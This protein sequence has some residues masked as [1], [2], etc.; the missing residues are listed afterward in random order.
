MG[1]VLIIT[2]AVIAFAAN[3][4]LTRIALEGQF[5]DPSAFALIRAVSGAA[6]L[7]MIISVR[8]EASQIFRSAR[9]VGAFS[10]A[11]Y[12]MGFSLALLTLDAGLGTLILFATVQITIFVY[13]ALGDGRLG[14]R[15][16]AGAGVAL[17]G[18]AMTIVPQPGNA[19]QTAGAILMILAGLGWATYTIAGR[20]SRDPLGA[21][22]GNFLLCLPLVLI[23][24]SG[25]AWT[26]S[27]TGIALGIVCGALTSAC[28]YVLWYSVL[29]QMNRASAAMAHMG[30]PVL[31]IAA[32]TFLLNETLGII[33]VLAALLII[34]GIGFSVTERTAQTDH[35]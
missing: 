23:F 35:G 21:T 7:G 30:V 33:Q 26:F 32:G 18:L 16:L 2:L 24:V 4:V 11:V 28:A 25:N 14:W 5:M 6:V 3:S 10:L 19:G 8:S 29:P 13:G 15:Q 9:A 34:A 22:A 12:I 20:N 1:H 27:I 31:A 17:L